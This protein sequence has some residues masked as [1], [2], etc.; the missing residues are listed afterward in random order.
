M[1]PI[2]GSKKSKSGR[3]SRCSSG[4]TRVRGGYRPVAALN[5]S[6][7]DSDDELREA[8]T[9]LAV[10][11]ETCG[12]VGGYAER[13]ARKAE[14]CWAGLPVFS[15]VAEHGQINNI[16]QFSL[17]SADSEP[18]FLTPL[19]E[20]NKCHEARARSRVDLFAKKAKATAHS[21]F[22][23][24]NKTTG[25]NLFFLYVQAQQNPSTAP[26]MLWTQ[27]GPGLSSLF[28]QFLEIGPLAIDA[29]GKLHKRLHTVQKDA[30]VIYL[31]V[32]V[33]AGYSFTK[34]PSWLRT[35][36]RRHQR[37][38]RGIPEAVLGAVPAIQGAGFLRRRRVLRSK[39]RH[40]NRIP[41]A[42]R[43]SQTVATELPRSRRGSRI[44][45]TN[46]GDNRFERIPLPIV[47]GHPG[48]SRYI[49]ER[50]R[51]NEEPLRRGQATRCHDDLAAYHLHRRQETHLVSKSHP[52]PQ[53][54]ECVV[55]RRARE[56][57]QVLRIREHE[58]VQGSN[59]RRAR[60][61]VSTA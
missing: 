30:S 47:D 37:R 56:H 24:V 21:G 59:T 36:S 18:L 25:S 8:T 7:V 57:A 11:V 19:I 16:C 15:D 28:G 35:K 10:A 34:D 41:P 48:R 1:S 33:E 4:R 26:L 27:G 39:I 40:R 45:R 12:R 46:L 53:P 44:P 54:G 17:S 42:H 55:L 3:S 2:D 51:K 6:R 50:I 58:N 13:R 22:I 43:A 5:L 32:P 20:Q 23:T 14:Q 38:G 61:P 29:D 9:V 31:D 52:L 49:R 60:C